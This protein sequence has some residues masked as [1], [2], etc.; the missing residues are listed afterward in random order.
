V[1]LSDIVKLAQISD[2]RQHRTLNTQ[3]SCN[4]RATVDEDG[5]YCFA[6]ALWANATKLASATHCPTE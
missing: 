3:P 6:V 5:Q 4:W 1:K 2:P